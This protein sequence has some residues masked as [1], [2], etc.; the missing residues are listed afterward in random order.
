MWADSRALFLNRFCIVHDDVMNFL[1]EFAT[2]LDPR[3]ALMEPGVA[4]NSG[5]RTRPA[6]SGRTGEFKRPMRQAC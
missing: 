6:Q 4:P 2:Q 5:S 3:V 1:L